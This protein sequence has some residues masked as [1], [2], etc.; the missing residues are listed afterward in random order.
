[1]NKDNIK[2]KFTSSQSIILESVVLGLTLLFV[3][4]FQKVVTKYLPNFLG[5]DSDVFVMVTIGAVLIILAWAGLTKKK[6]A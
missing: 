1:M 2:E 6:T 4:A 3:G 5:L